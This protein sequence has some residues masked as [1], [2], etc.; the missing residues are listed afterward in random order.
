MEHKYPPFAWHYSFQLTQRS[1]LSPT[2]LVLAANQ[3]AMP[4]TPLVG[5]ASMSLARWTSF[6]SWNNFCTPT[7]TVPS[8]ARPIPQTNCGLHS[9]CSIFNNGW[10]GAR[11]P[12]SVSNSSSHPCA[13][14]ACKAVQQS[15]SSQTVFL[16]SGLS[17]LPHRSTPPQRRHCKQ[18]YSFYVR[19]G[20]QLSVQGVIVEVAAPTTPT[21]VNG[22][23]I[24]TGISLALP[25]LP[26]GST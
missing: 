14:S 7:R 11:S 18:Q 17:K 21:A 22:N 8:L 6:E 20:A 19:G 2:C 4:P 5:D 16:P 25:P 26:P 9:L 23:I 1:P 12:S 3:A 15:A 24:F 13:S 10:V